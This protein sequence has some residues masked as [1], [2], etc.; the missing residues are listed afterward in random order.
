MRAAYGVAGFVLDDG[1][2]TALAEHGLV[3]GVVAAHMP[4]A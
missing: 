3:P 1:V 2:L 4:R